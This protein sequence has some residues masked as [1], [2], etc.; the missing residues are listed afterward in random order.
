MSDTADVVVVGAGII[1]LS[2]AYQLALRSSQRIVVLEKAA[3]V[4]EGSTGASCAIL[5][6]RYTYPDAIRMA[7]DGLGTYR[8]WAEYTGVA[9][10]RGKFHHTGVLWMMG[11]TADDVEEARTMMS[12]LGIAVE[13]LDG[14]AVNERFPDY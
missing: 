3:N 14:A 11:D 4:G 10:P 13:H 5:R 8:N 2:I 6:Q 9:E 7:R 1:G 12:G